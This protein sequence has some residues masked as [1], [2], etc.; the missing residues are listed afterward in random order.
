MASIKGIAI[1][2]MNLNVKRA[3]HANDEKTFIQSII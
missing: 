3:A 2:D 1:P